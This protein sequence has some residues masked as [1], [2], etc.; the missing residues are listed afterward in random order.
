[1]TTGNKTGHRDA[2]HALDIGLSRAAALVDREIAESGAV[3]RVVGRVMAKTAAR[4]VRRAAWFA[5]AAAL[6]L[7]ACLGSLA[8]L[9]F[10]GGGAPQRQEVVVLEPLIFGP[11]DIDPQ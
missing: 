3:E 4:P 11:A 7:A 2:I 6:V 5:I 8:D 10:L 9:T 1:M